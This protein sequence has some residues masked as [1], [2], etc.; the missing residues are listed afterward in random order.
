MSDVFSDA[1]AAPTP[2][3][4][5]APATATPVAP[6]AP[7][8]AATPTA[9]PQ[10]PAIG[11]A[12]EGFVPSYRLRETREQIERQ[13]QQQWSQR[14]AELNSRYA[15]MERKLQVLAG[16]T[17]PQNPEVEAIKQQFGQVYPGLS[18]VEANAQK[19]LDL[20]DRAGDLESQTNH[21]WQ[22]YGRQR[23]DRLFEHAS[24]SLGGSITEEA[25]RVLHAAFSGFVSSSPEMTQRYANDPTLVDEFWQAFSSSFIDPSRRAATAQTVQRVPG[26]IPQDTPGGAPRATLGPQPSNLDERAAQAWAQ[27]QSQTR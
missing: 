24:A 22:D 20:L 4:T 9:T 11:G 26:A 15:E 13:Y 25:K 14:E 18:K 16:V 7:V 3:A 12:P 2:A 27:Y 8:A 5:P 19:L 10:P 17:P 23:M 21:Y 6:A 1:G